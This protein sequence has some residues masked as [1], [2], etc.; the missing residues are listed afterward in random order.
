MKNVKKTFQFKRR[1]DPATKLSQEFHEFFEL[2]S[3]KKVNKLP[4]HRFYDH[5]INFI[6]KKQLGYGPLY[7]MS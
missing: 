2:F 1:T 7:S 6:K 3:E 4:P 5:K